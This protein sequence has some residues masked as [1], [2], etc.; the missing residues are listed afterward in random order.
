MFSSFLT[1]IMAIIIDVI[2]TITVQ[3]TSSTTGNFLTYETPGPGPGFRHSKPTGFGV[4]GVRHWNNA[5]QAPSL[6]II[7]TRVK[8][9]YMEYV[10]PSISIPL[11]QQ[12]YKPE[13]TLIPDWWIYMIIPINMDSWPSPNRWI[14]HLVLVVVSHLEVSK[15]M[16][17]PEVTTGFNTKSC[18]FHDIGWLGDEPP[19]IT[20]TII[21]HSTDQLDQLKNSHLL[22]C[23]RA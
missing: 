17:V 3:Y 18:S 15:K 2:T 4:H 23:C 21:N 6:I 22:S 8:T 1:T 20:S 7:R 19:S 11:I 5:P 10:H 14:I 12:K 16:E 13:S 9:W